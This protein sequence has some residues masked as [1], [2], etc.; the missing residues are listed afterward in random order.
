LCASFT[1]AA[2]SSRQHATHAPFGT[3]APRRETA[4][5]ASD[6]RV[7][8]Y[9]PV[10]AHLTNKKQGVPP[11]KRVVVE[12]EQAR[13]N[14]LR[15]LDLLDT[16]PSESFDRITRLA[17]RLLGAPVSTISLTDGDRQWFKSRYGVDLAEIPRGDAPCHYAIA[18]DEVF[19]VPDLLEDA[20]FRDSLLA[21]AGMRFYAG[22]PLI[23]RSGY[24]LGTLCVVD[25][26]P[27]AI[28]EEERRVLADLA[29]M[30]MTQIEVQNTIGRVDATTGQANEHRLF[31]DIED[32]ARQSAAS[33]RVGLLIE[34]L[35]QH[36]VNRGLRVLGVSYAQDLVRAMMAA[37]RQ[38]IG[39]T[40]RLYHVGVM[41]CAVL[42][43]IDPQQALPFARRLVE[44]LQQ[45]ISAAGIPV[46]PDP[47]IGVYVFDA[48]EV[49]P[50][51]VLKR[52]LGALDD[53][54]AT[55]RAVAVHSEER[56]L[57]HARHFSVLSAIGASLAAGDGLSLVYQPRVDLAT[58]RCVAA[59][60]LL[61][62]HHPSLGDVPPGEFIP[63][64]EG[65]GLTRPL[66]E[67]VMNA[68]VSGCAA[69]RRDG[70]PARIS[71]NASARN[72]EESDFADRMALALQRHQVP[73][74]A[75]ELEFTENAVLGDS[76]RVREQLVALTEIGVSIAIDDFGTGYS[77]LSNLRQLPVSVL[78][79][80]RSFIGALGESER[81]RR[82]VR[83]MI[84]MAHDLGYR[85]V[86]EGVE[87]REACD[88][89]ASWDCDEAQGFVFARPM[90]SSA[91]THWI[92]AR[93]GSAA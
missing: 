21:R 3:A 25:G 54:R 52:L 65:T 40:G 92:G 41:R 13:L 29:A 35:P 18:R 43:D 19:V 28:G 69:W 23:T 8:E 58:Q 62:W 93:V 32:L 10:S 5:R 63:L 50:Q 1:V 66:T 88:L 47:A 20:R 15:D 27:R 45:P 24:G 83:T 17:G 84:A 67:W 51:D 78:K 14:A 89:L 12:N 70:R 49:A 42:L 68:A 60:A 59:E 7:C 57:G 6:R 36:D 79:I 34:L 87:T 16:P 4:S 33:R 22:A 90:P 85:V 56:D 37:L 80:D 81:D 55:T 38:A 76:R 30:V 73:A 77:N 64:V 72:L 48:A 74:E 75:I 86:A 82:L 61:R 2:H 11:M 71:I 9:L 91:M 39:N 44:R 26:A 53:A 31:E 46:T